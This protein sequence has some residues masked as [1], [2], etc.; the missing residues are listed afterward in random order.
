VRV[1]A[2]TPLAEYGEWTHVAAVYDAAAERMRLY[3]NGDLAGSVAMTFEQWK[4]TG[5]FTVG[6]GMTPG[7]PPFGSTVGAVDEV[8]IFQSVLTSD[9][10][11]ELMTGEGLP[12][13]LQAWYPLRGDGADHSGRAA[14]LTAMPETPSWREDQHGRASSALDLNGAICPTAETAPVRTDSAFTVSAWAR[15]DADHA[16]SHP[17]VFTFGGDFAFSVMAKYNAAT[18]KWNVAVTAEDTA[19]P[20]WGEGAVST[21]VASEEEWTQIAVTAD[22]DNNIIQLFVN[23]QLSDTGA[24]STT[25]DTWRASEFVIGCGSLSDGTRT[26]QWDGAISDVRVW[27]GAL[28]AAEVAATHAERISHWELDK[29]PAIQ[30][31]DQWGANDLTFH[32]SVGWETDRW[33]D[34]WAAYG[35]D[36]TGTGYAS[37][38]TSVVRTDESFSVSAWAKIDDNNDHRVVASQITDQDASFYLAYYANTDRWQFAL[39]GMDPSGPVW[40]TV[41][42]D[43]ATEVGRW[44]HLAATYDLGRGEISLYVDGVLQNVADGPEHPWHGDG[45]L[46]LGATGNTAGERWSHMAGSIDQVYAWTGVID[47]HR[48]RTYA[49]EHPKPQ[50]D[51]SKPE[52]SGTTPPDI[53]D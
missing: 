10:I 11:E 32:G 35:L 8:A 40:E 50:Q 45:Q 18:D 26:S 19:V 49:A 42:A 16:N 48:I 41:E 36:L 7:G 31:T 24:I 43:E 4:A 53:P 3:V 21:Q 20:D 17:R 30:G 13:A 37:T 23:G 52:C 34:C 2:D 14:D 33:D 6:C 38:T 28:D 5:L 25:W 29:N 27:R 1:T 51:T 44:Y 47:P 12:A 22:T 46:L 39:K 15:L 9:Q